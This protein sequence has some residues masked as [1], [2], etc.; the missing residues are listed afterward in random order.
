MKLCNIKFE[1]ETHL[2]VVKGSCVIDMTSGG[3][4]LIMDDLIKGAPLPAPTGNENI[5]PLAD[6][7][8][9][10]V[11]TPGKIPC[12]GLN[13][14]KHARETGGEPPKEPVIFSKF[15]DCL[16]PSGHAVE[17]PRWQR[18]F[19]Y[20][21]ELVIIMGKEAWHITPEEAK[22]HVF[23]YTCG[24]DLSARDCQFI[25]N[26]WLIGKTFPDFAPCG[27][28]IVT[29][30]EF[31]PDESH[32]ITCRRNGQIVQEDDINDMLFDVSTVIS[33][34]SKYCR[35]M[36]GDVIFTGTPSGVILGKPKGT[37]DWLKPGEEVSVTID[38]IGTLVNK[39]I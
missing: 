27:P 23:G 34:I 31:D 6:V 17:L 21:A 35:L 37:R 16:C 28:F 26:Q 1:N 10:N 5:L 30:D 19:D 7:T 29:A 12:V 24:N 39:L 22:S 36:P 8:F 3:C 15:N 9:A 20:E 4:P 38:G 11:C 2:G 13:Y 18:C 33:Y 32:V 25:S 14:N